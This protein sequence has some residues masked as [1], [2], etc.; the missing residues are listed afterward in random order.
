MG[1]QLWPNDGTPNWGTTITITDTGTIYGLATGDINQDGLLDVVSCDDNHV[2]A[3]TQDGIGGWEDV[4]PM[5][6]VGEFNQV[7]LGDI[8][9][10]G[11][12]D[13]VAAN[14]QGSGNGIRSLG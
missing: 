1:L 12:L 3:Y 7:D 5:G 13:I 10:D 6:N 4:I 11:T 8:N 9:N 14:H 2:Y